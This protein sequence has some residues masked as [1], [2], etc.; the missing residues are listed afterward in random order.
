[1]VPRR[2]GDR[3]RHRPLQHLAGRAVVRRLSA[4]RH[5]PAG[6]RLRTNPAAPAPGACEAHQSAVESRRAEPLLHRRSRRDQQW[7]PPAAQPSLAIAADRFGTYVGGGIT[8][9]WSDMLGDHNLVT[10]AQ[11]QGRIS[12]FAALVA[13]GNRKSR[14]NWS[15]GAQQIPYIL[16]GFGVYQD[17]N[18]GVFVEEIQRFKQTNRQL[19]G[20]VAYPFNR[21]D[22]VE[23]SAGLQQISYDYEL[24]KHGFNLDGSVAFDSTIHLPVPPAATFE[25]TRS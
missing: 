2:F 17:P 16:G 13:Y 24:K 19:S 7:L 14:L 11:V 12:D 25:A 3:V 4:G 23:V 15:V 5:R 21:S 6:E 22:R 9:F 10:M 18:T 1:M 20:V 8:L